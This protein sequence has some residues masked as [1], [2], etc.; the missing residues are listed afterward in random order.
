MGVLDSRGEHHIQLLRSPTRRSFAQVVGDGG[1]HTNP[2][3]TLMDRLGVS[4]FKVLLRGASK[5]ALNCADWVL[6]NSDSKR[7]CACTQCGCASKILAMPALVTLT[8]RA[9]RSVTV[10]SD[11]DITVAFKRLQIMSDSSAVHCKQ[12]AERQHS[13]WPALSKKIA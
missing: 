4:R 10:V 6:P 8:N 1:Q 12:F 7:S 3:S 2:L 5:H 9:R 13:K 11:C